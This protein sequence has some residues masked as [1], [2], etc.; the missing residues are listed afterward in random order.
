MLFSGIGLLQ[1]QLKRTFGAPLLALAK[2]IY[3]LQNK[4]RHY[5]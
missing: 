2:Y 1:M 5:R 4:K 3:I